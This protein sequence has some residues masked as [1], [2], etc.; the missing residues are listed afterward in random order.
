MR[1]LLQAHDVLGDLA[2]LHRRHAA[3]WKLAA[4]VARRVDVRHVALAMAVDGDEPTTVDLDTGSIEA[5]AVA[6]GNGPDRQHRVRA[7]HDPAIVATNDDRVVVARRSILHE[8][9]STGAR[10]AAGSRLRARRRPRD[11]SGQDLL[12]ADDQGDLRAEAAE[13]VHE[14]DAG[15]TGSDHR[16]A[17]REDRRRI[18]IACRQD[19]LAIGD[20]PVGN[21]RA[22]T[23]CHEHGIRRRWCEC[24]PP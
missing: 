8:R 19:P 11:P 18:A 24:P 3:E 22:A 20:A 2:T 4:D 16:D 17:L 23:G 14:L 13:H 5:E 21:A 10:H 15:D 1:H 9:P 7:V 6:V 12:A